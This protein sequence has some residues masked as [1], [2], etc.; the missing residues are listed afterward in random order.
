[1]D[2]STS[3]G[4]INDTRIEKVKKLHES[5]MQKRKLLL[6]RIRSRSHTNKK[7]EAETSR[8]E[9]EKITL[10]SKLV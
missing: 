7:Q 6:D 2:K 4:S 5:N 10:E 9:N 3:R 8:I 1:L